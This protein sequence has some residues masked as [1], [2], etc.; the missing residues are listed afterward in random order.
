M[1]F[2]VLSGFLITFLLLEE[3]ARTSRISIRHFYVRRALRIWPLYYLVVILALYV[4]PHSDAL[5]LPGYGIERVQEDL[6]LKTAL[7]ATF[8]AN[9]AL[10]TLGLVP[11]AGLT[12]SIAT[13]EQFYLIWPILMKRTPSRLGLMLAV[14]LAYLAGR[15]AL[16]YGV[17]GTGPSLERIRTFYGLLNVD[18]M[19][20]GGLAAVFLHQK[21]RTLSILVNLP[22]FLL[23]L[24]ATAALIASGTVVP[25]LNHEAYAVCFALLILN[26]A[27]HPRLARCLE[28]EPCHFLGKISYGLYLL[29]PIAI[30]LSIHLLGGEAPAMVLYPACLLLTVGLAALSYRF[31]E[32]P[33]LRW[34]VRYAA[35]PS[36]GNA[37]PAA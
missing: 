24:F 7:Y 35:V 8:F 13:E 21:A 12:W 33:F 28:F 32:S 1:L 14:I 30:V 31:I 18:C 23:V 26:F 2:F 19:A 37:P 4:L 11:F 22:L 29:H 9:V 17:L 3:E 34:K 10:V 20:I 25:Y 15:F 6:A 36:G 27:V 5:T 16:D